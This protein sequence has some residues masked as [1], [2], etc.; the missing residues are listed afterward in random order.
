MPA[1]ASNREANQT[2]LPS[3]S[4]AHRGKEGRAGEVGVP[5]VIHKLSHAKLRHQ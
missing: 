2:L 3:L 1:Y 4:R 5:A